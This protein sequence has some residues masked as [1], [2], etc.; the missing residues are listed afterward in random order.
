PKGYLVNISRGSVIDEAALLAALKER[1]SAGAALDVFEV[2]DA[3]VRLLLVV[4]AFA[5]L[6]AV[7]RKAWRARSFDSAMLVVAGLVAVGFGLRDW[8]VSEVSNDFVPVL[9]TPY[10]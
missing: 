4:S 9:L 8:I 5:A 3:A 6:A 2:I 10:A 7:A 1:R